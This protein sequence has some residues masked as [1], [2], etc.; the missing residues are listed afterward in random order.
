MNR[1]L[2][3]RLFSS[4]SLALLV[5]LVAQ[6]GQCAAAGLEANAYVGGLLGLHVPDAE[7]TSARGAFGI[8][9]GAKLGSEYAIGGYY[10]SSTKNEETGTGGEQKF[11][12]TMY[13]VE[14]AY[15]FEGEALG[16]YFGARLGLTQ[17]DVGLADFSPYHVA[18]LAG[19][20]HWLNDNLSIGGELSF[21]HVNSDTDVVGTTKVPSDAFNI[22]AFMASVK[23]WL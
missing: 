15:H 2:A 12:Y 19:Y 21:T 3:V 4:L 11:A 13:G 5:F 6:N 20:N 1:L 9:G 16:A 7:D 22:I 14:G 23:F 18:A 8:V 10:F 17:M